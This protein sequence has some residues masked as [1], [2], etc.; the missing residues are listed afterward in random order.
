[1]A[2]ESFS[3]KV[4]VTHDVHSHSQPYIQSRPKRPME[5][6]GVQI[7]VTYKNVGSASD[8]NT[9]VRQNICKEDKKD[10]SVKHI[11]TIQKG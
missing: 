7:E 4:V 1:M 2:S 8:R 3:L 10:A 5:S 6:Y 9:Q 11:A